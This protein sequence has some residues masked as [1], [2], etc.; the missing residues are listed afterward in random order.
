MRYFIASQ[1]S[2]NNF[3]KTLVS[4]ILV[5]SLTANY[6]KP[7][8]INNSE[9]KE[10]EI[11]DLI[12]KKVIIYPE[13]YNVKQELNQVLEL[14]KEKT[15]VNL[16]NIIPPTSSKLIIETVGSILSPLNSQGINTSDMLSY[17]NASVILVTEDKSDIIKT[18]N[19]IELLK[20]KTFP[21]KGIICVGELNVENTLKIEHLTG[22]KTLITIP[23]IEYITK[24][25]VKVQARRIK[26]IIIR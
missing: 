20:S 24:E 25:F 22:V 10:T 5:Q 17:C 21:I 13:A 4:A 16:K 7:I 12:S 2:K 3:S 14:N 8:Q 11:I 18:I 23:K 9:E 6:W 15:E 1:E 19:V 26:N